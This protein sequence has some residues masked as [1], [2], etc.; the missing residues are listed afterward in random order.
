MLAESYLI[1]PQRQI[2]EAED[3]SSAMLINVS[4]TF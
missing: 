3:E 1:A 4:P 2:S